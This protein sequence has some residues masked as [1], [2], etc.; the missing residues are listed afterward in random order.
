M[1]LSVTPFYPPGVNLGAAMCQMPTDI[2]F[3][4]DPQDCAIWQHDPH[5]IHELA[6]ACGMR[7]PSIQLF[8]EGVWG[9]PFLE[10][11][12]C[13]QDLLAIAEEYNA[14][15][16]SN[17][18]WTEVAPDSVSRDIRVKAVVKPLSPQQMEQ[19]AQMGGDRFANDED[20]SSVKFL[21]RQ[22]ALDTGSWAAENGNMPGADALEVWD[23]YL[24][25]L[26]PEK[27][28]NKKVNL[29]R[30]LSNFSGICPESAREKNVI[31]AS[32]VAGNPA[33]LGS[34]LCKARI[35]SPVTIKRDYPEDQ[36]GYAVG[37]SD[38]GKVYI[39]EKFRSYIPSVGES[40]S[41]T[42][43]L[44]PASE[45]KSFPLTCIYLH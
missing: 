44:Q 4:C 13:D 10:P 31:L 7:G 1:S 9:Q 37:E 15:E 35:E 8:N 16:G 20:T 19:A 24:E 39:P 28:Q 11:E 29:H 12:S 21:H 34:L 25:S 32:Q 36:R 26:I 40:V 6:D 22:Y 38:Y 30:H 45:K 3:W 18:K 41:M 33:T 42:L 17:S 23:D 2:D 14:L 27:V 43:A 5:I